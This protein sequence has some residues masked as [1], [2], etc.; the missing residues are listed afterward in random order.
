MEG[1]EY[2]GLRPF[3]VIRFSD[4]GSTARFLYDGAKMLDKA[5]T[6]DGKSKLIYTNKGDPDSLYYETRVEYLNLA[7]IALSNRKTFLRGVAKPNS[8]GRIASFAGLAKQN[9]PGRIKV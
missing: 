2:R 3:A 4:E 1:E 7:F 6:S 8:P 5:V 9:S